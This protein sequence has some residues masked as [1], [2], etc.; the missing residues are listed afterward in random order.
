LLLKDLEIVNDLARATGS[1]MPVTA[2]VT[3][4]YRLLAA[5]GHT[6][7]GATALVQ[8]YEA[9]QPTAEET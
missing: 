5:Q 1:P 6:P 8:L 3:T 4:L 9:K 7:G 2:V